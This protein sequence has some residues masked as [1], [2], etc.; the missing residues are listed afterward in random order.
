MW[1]TVCAA[2]G[3][4]AT[5]WALHPARRS[6]TLSDEERAATIAKNNDAE[7]RQVAIAVSDGEVLRAWFIR[8]FKNNGSAVILFHGQADNRAG[9]LG[10]AA[11]LLRNGYSVLMPDARAHGMSGGALATYGFMEAEDVRQWFDWLVQ[12]QTPHC[13]DGL[14]ESMGAAL[15]LNSLRSE[16]GFCAVV[17]ES[18]FANFRE[19]SYARIGQFAG[20]GPWLGRT[21]LR[22]AVEFSFLYARLRYGA[23]LT[24]DDPAEAVAKSSVPVLLIHGQLDSNLSSHHSEMILAKSRNRR[25]EIVLWEPP[26]AGHCGA[27]SAEPEKFERRVIGWFATHQTASPTPQS[28]AGEN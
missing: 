25:G 21:V 11:L 3:V 18:P 7:V 8:P 27:A 20:T 24:Q 19:A 26:Y 1:L 9:M 6:L 14:G 13:I 5:Q 12:M 28:V 16:Q 22:P 10:P 23:D 2:A 17:A 4:M 15:L